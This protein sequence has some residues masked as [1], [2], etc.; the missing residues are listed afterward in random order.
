MGRHE[1]AKCDEWS[2]VSGG[3]LRCTTEETIEDCIAAIAVSGALPPR[4]GSDT[5]THG[6]FA[7]TFPSASRLRCGCHVL[8]PPS[9][10]PPHPTPPHPT[11]QAL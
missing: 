10:A 2:A 6:A 3:A 7:D 8:P 5:Q 11:F 9:K 4:L 1:R